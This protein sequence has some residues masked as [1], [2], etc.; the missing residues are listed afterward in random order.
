MNYARIE[1]GAVA[2]Y[3]LSW[4]QVKDAVYPNAPS[5]LSPPEGY[6]AIKPMPAPNPAW[7]QDYREVTPVQGVA[8]WE[9]R[10]ELF[11]LEGAALAAA[12]EGLRLKKLAAIDAARDQRM[13]SGFTFEGVR[14][15][16]DPEAQTN[17]MGAVLKG[18]IAVALGAPE[19]D[20]YRWGSADE[21]FAWIAQDNTRTRMDIATQRRLA[22]AGAAWKSAHIFA[23]RTKKDA[24]LAAT[25]KAELDAID[26]TSGWP[27]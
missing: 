21:D 18:M 1:N 7:N 16:S 10:W 17:L 22:E 14:Y 3:P 13:N 15:D 27:E 4:Q 8:G 19:T 12:F 5:P 11:T 2:E 20:F 25:T 6:V 9:Q 23:A 26:P 24:A